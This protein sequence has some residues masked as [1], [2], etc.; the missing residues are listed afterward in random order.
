M[1]SQTGTDNGS[2]RSAYGEQ[3]LAILRIL[4]GRPLAYHPAFARMYGI[5]A[6]VMLGQ[7]LYW[8]E[9]GYDPDGWIKKTCAEMEEETALSEKEQET[10]RAR[11][12]G[13]GVIEYQMRGLPAMPNYRVDFDRLAD[14]IV[15]YQQGRPKRPSK[16]GQ[17]GLASETPSK[18]SKVGQNGL[19]YYPETTKTETT[20]TETTEEERAGGAPPSAPT[21]STPADSLPA[22]SIPTET[23]TTASASGSDALGQAPEHFKR[24]PG[25]TAPANLRTM[26]APP[27][28]TARGGKLSPANFTA[29]EDERVGLYLQYL[30]SEITPTNA[31]IILKRVS[32]DYLPQW[33]AAIADMATG[34]GRGKS[35]KATDFALL[36]E[37]YE[38]YVTAKKAEALYAET[39]TT[40]APA[41]AAP[42][43]KPAAVSPLLQKL[44]ERG[45][46]R[47]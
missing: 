3:A 22:D 20:K 7:L 13:A 2:R 38:G 18:G 40:K 12:K 33:K 42:A 26:G 39:R 8:D 46:S 47:V 9:K 23:E 35:Y 10:A 21:D 15:A 17:N 16:V 25:D 34:K 24:E 19:A 41:P 11:L 5:K 32:A 36:F 44:Q 27:R 28:K 37:L 31:E 29:H 1:A 4:G 6:G 14:E 45:V 43:A 30:R